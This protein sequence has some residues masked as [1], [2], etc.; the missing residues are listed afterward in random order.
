MSTTDCDVCAAFV[1]LYSS[2][3]AHS[4]CSWNNK[5]INN[6]VGRY[7]TCEMTD[8]HERMTARYRSVNNDHLYVLMGW[9]DTADHCGLTCL[10]SPAFCV[11][12]AR[13]DHW[14]PDDMVYES[15]DNLHHEHSKYLTNDKYRANHAC[16]NFYCGNVWDDCQ[17]EVG[18]RLRSRDWARPRRAYRSLPACLP[19]PAL[20]TF[21]CV[22]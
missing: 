6:D 4:S 10:G 2:S 16:I 21:I 14:A 8:N 19:Q 15:H 9:A 5:E 7:W 18:L 3:S 1:P 12:Q 20:L 11:E 22:S 13:R 17:I